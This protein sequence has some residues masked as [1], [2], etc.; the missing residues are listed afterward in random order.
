MRL[1]LLSAF[2]VLSGFGPLR[3]KEKELVV[4]TTDSVRLYVKVKGEGPYLLYLHGGPRAGSYWLEKF[5]GDFFERHFTMV[6]LD[7]R[8]TG[9]STGPSNGDYSMKR[10]VEDFE[11][12]RKALHV[13]RWLTLGHSFGG[14]LQMGYA[15]LAP[16]AVDGMLMLNCTLSLDDSFENGWLKK[17]GKLLG[18]NERAFLKNDS[19]SCLEKLG[20][21][22]GKLEG[23]N[24][25]WK[26]FYASPESDA[27]INRSYGEIPDFNTDFANRSFSFPEYF[28]DYRPFSAEINIPVLFFY[29][30]NDWAVGPKHYRNVRFPN[31]ILWKSDVGHMPFL[32]NREDMQKAVLAFGKRNGFL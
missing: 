28:R 30:R 12:V 7:Q 15:D 8:G 2:I 26:I 32:E 11:Q 6:Y 27:E 24:L 3:G 16:G 20:I 19:L 9:R 23:K 21:A 14:I 18:K 1:V 31:M 10:M 25:R 29:G 4:T 22:A 13:D 17:A 5:S